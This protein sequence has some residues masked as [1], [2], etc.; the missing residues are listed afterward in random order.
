MEMVM[1]RLS[2]S[3]LDAVMRG[4]KRL[5]TD[6]RSCVALL[7]VASV[8]LFATSGCT[9]ENSKQVVSQIAA[10]IP[11]ALSVV[12]LATA[13]ASGIDP[14]AS[15]LITATSSTVQ[16]G[17]SELKVLCDAYAQSPS[18]TALASI[19]DA[20]NKVLNANADALLSA[21]HIVDPLSKTAALAALGLLQGAL[22]LLYGILQRVQTKAQVTATAAMRTYKLRDVAPYLDHQQV[23]QAT[24]HSFSTCLQYEEAQGF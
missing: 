16:V 21:L 20:L 11:A 6:A 8:C 9:V 10:Q 23:E 5:Q 17:L 13:A 15:L 3:P 18:A 22:Q 19:N 14:G 24:G 12:A 4:I 2:A 1:G 7:L